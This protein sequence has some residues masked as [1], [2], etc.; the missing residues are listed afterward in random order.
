MYQRIVCFKFKADASVVAINQFM[1]A[2]KA[3]EA[4]IPQ[5][6]TYHGG[7]VLVENGQDPQYD[8]MHY[9]T[10]ATREDIEVYYHHSA[11]QTFVQKYSDLWERV[12]VLNAPVEE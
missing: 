4:A 10:F 7:R 11:H 1:A 6:E 12:L 9:L 5:I 2:F 8:S 3:L